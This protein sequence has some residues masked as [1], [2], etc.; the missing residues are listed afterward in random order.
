MA[1][2]AKESPRQK[3]INLMYLVFICMLALNMSKEVLAAFG[4]MNVKMEASNSKTADGNLAFLE[5]LETKAGEDAT[6]YGPLLKNAKQIKKL[7][8]DYFDYIQD[9]KTK[10]TK[11]LE[12]P[13]QKVRSSCR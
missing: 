12:D 2:G 11:D 6:K 8:Q 10:M 7:S 1:G 13:L 3:M 5:S 9:I 4:I